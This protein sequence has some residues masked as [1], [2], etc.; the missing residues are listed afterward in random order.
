MAGLEVS[1]LAAAGGGIASFLS[2]CVLPLV[3]AYL[4]FVTGSTLDELAGSDDQEASVTTAHAVSASLSF[5]LG[6]STVFVAL[7]ASASAVSAGL[8]ENQT[9]LAQAAG[10]IIIALGLHYVGLFRI[11]LLNREIRFNPATKLPGW[12]G[13]YVIGV[14]FAFGWTPCI[15]PILG[16]ILAIAATRDTL[17]FGISLLAVYSLGLG[18]PFVVA[19]MSIRSFT[20]FFQGFRRHL[21]TVEMVAGVLLIGTGVMFVTGSFQELGYLMQAWFP[22]LENIG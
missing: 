13:A 16:T 3:P 4:C 5:V 7:G 19:A 22:D 2:P 18:V 14:A 12:F 20:G 17:G 8:R 9:L 15:G 11:G 21:R 1:Y 6:F 10:L